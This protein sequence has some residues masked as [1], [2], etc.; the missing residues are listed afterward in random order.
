MKNEDYRKFLKRNGI[1]AQDK[2]SV[3]RLFDSEPK[4]MNALNQNS[5]FYLLG[6]KDTEYI[7]EETIE[8][9][10]ENNFIPHTIDKMSRG[11]R[12]I[13]IDLINPLTGRLMTGSSS[14]TAINVLEDYNDIGLGTDGGGSV[15]AP[16]MALNLYGIISPLFFR[17]DSYLKSST[18]GIK[19]VPSLGF[20]SKKIEIIKKATETF[21]DLPELDEIDVLVPTHENVFLETGQDVGEILGDCFNSNK[22]L[23]INKSVYPNIF[24]DRQPNIDFLTEMLTN[25][26]VVMSYEGPVDYYGLGD[27]V[28]GLFNSIS[29]ENQQKAGKGLIRV[30]NM[31]NASA[32]VVPTN[33]F[34]SGYVIIAKSTP[35]G[36]NCLFEIEKLLTNKLSNKLYEKYFTINT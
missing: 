22:K 9:L 3:V 16:A 21:I 5:S 10:E 28:F 25:H 31:C 26:D 15:L 34:S 12:A 7:K 14:G 29:R 17:D 33:D 18:D 24:G 23:K 4:I 19:F 1:I 2:K 27:S 20:I 13:D 30:A 6:L 32:L 8:K 35:R 36:V 11:G